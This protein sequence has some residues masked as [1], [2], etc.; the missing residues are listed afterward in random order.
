MGKGG[1]VVNGV[2][3]GVFSLFSVTNTSSYVTLAEKGV[4]TAFIAFFLHIPS[5]AIFVFASQLASA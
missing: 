2:M 3:D 5:S 1:L 4:A